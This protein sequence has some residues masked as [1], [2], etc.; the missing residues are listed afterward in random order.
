MPREGAG[1]KGR[2]LH[3]QN[4]CDRLYV[5]SMVG[6]FLLLLVQ[7]QVSFPPFKK[8]KKIELY[9]FPVGGGQDR[10]RCVVEEVWGDG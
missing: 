4:I 2:F 1:S 5:D 9:L 3:I 6:V 7:V 10:R 8:K